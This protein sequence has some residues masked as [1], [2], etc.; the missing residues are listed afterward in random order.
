MSSLTAN[1]ARNEP[2]RPDSAE[3]AANITVTVIRM[4]LRMPVRSE[5]PPTTTPAMAQVSENAEASAPTWVLDNPSS[6]CTN[7]MR[8]LS[9]LR[10]KNRMPKFRHNR[11]TS[12]GWYQVGRMFMFRSWR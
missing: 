1:S 12:T 4:G 8:K 7:G 5:K 9:A 10:S 6:G 3:Q 2:T 11:T